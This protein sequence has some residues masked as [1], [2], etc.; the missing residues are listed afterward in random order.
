MNYNLSNL[1]KRHVKNATWP[2]EQKLAAV[3]QYLALGNM[4]LVSATTGIDYGLLRKWK[5]EDWW[6]EFE[7]E[8]RNT[9][10]LQ[11]DTKLTKIVDRS[12]EAVADRL[13]N[14]DY[15]YDSKTGRMERKPVAMKDAAKVSVDLLTKRELLRGNATS[16]TETTAVPVADQLKFLAAE[17]ARMTS[18][19][20]IEPAID[21][22]MVEILTGDVDDAKAA[23]DPDFGDADQILNN[24]ELEEDQEFYDGTD[25]EFEPGA[26]SGEEQFDPDLDKPQSE[27]I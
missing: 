10:N 3:T 7:R 21:V 9:D 18:G 22:E 19:K 24:D 4:R 26:D 11:L 8:I 6:K 17:F 23:M 13:E 14:G 12:L 25:G 2:K 1:R 16:R 27:T 5:M 15:I 20:P